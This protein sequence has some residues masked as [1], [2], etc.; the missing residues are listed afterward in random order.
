MPIGKKG[1]PVKSPLYTGGSTPPGLPNKADNQKSG[2][3]SPTGIGS[4]KN[5][6]A[7]QLPAPKRI[8]GSL[9]THGKTLPDLGKSKHKGG[10]GY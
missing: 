7:G 9:A 1:G 2:T 4:G 6:P 8:K 5:P 10:F 3:V